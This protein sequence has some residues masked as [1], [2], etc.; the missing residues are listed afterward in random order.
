M[1]LDIFALILWMIYG[2]FLI[3]VFIMSFSWVDT[4]YYLFFGSKYNLLWVSILF[5][6]VLGSSTLSL[7]NDVF[8]SLVWDIG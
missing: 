2:S 1:D 7:T 8:F 4:T 6:L 3:V 5:V